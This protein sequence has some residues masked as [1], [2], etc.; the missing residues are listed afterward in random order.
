LEGIG[1]GSTIIS[2]GDVADY[3]EEWRRRLYKKGA[4][5]LSPAPGY[6]V[7]VIHGAVVQEAS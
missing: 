4:G 2:S 7:S 1:A 3:R 5:V 6:A